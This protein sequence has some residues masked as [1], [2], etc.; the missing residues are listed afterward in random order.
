[1]AV[2]SFVI[3]GLQFGALVS[4]S[5]FLKPLVAEFGWER[6]NTA[7]AYT[8]GAG[9]AGL[10][11]IVMGW[12]ADRFSTRPVVLFGSVM[13]G[14]SLLLLSY[15]ETLWQLYL[16]YCILGGLGF[17]ALNV[18]IITNVGQWFSRNKGLA[19]GIVSAGGALGQGLV[20]YFARYLM[21][22]SGWRGAYTTLAV[23][24]WAMLLPLA[25]LIRTPP[26]LAKDKNASPSGN[27][28]GTEEVYPIAPA[29]VVIWLSIAV[30][31]CCICM[32]TPIIH[33]VALASD[34][35]FNSQSA[36][37]VLSL[38]MIAGL[39]GRI[40]FGKIADSIGGL[41]TYL[42]ASAAQT[43]L[44]FWFT[45]LHSLTGLYILAV[46]FGLGFSGVMTCIWVSVRE[47]TPPRSGGLSLGIVNLFGWIGMG[48]GGYQGGLFFDLTGNYTV[49]YANAALAGV[50][51]LMILG[52][53]LLYVTRKQAALE[54]EMK[55][56]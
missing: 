15:L 54:Y 28:L 1:M 8:A 31:F 45:Q 56:A 7:F 10:G 52:S 49:S 14:L 36:A 2:V 19:L 40:F 53:L 32:A 4:I 3:M 26:R 48:L 55:E 23:I 27:P 39:F 37:G 47:M 38:I 46:L 16:F 50:V 13:L 11:G 25:L 44:V 17:A 29:K 22:F 18:P 51:N 20:P 5:V 42:L 9:A 30:I 12:M 33:V 43:T 41:R 24:F 6:G 21:I 35:G 34:M